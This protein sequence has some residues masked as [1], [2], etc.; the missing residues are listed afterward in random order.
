M[1]IRV[2]AEITHEVNYAECHMGNPIIRSLHIK[3]GNGEN[4]ILRIRSTPE[5][6]FVYKKEIVLQGDQVISD[7]PLQLNNSFYRQ[8]IQETIDATVHVELVDVNYQSK[9][10]A[11]V[12]EPVRV[13]AYLHWN[14]CENPAALA[15]FMQPND[16]FIS[17]VLGRAGEL[18]NKA[19]ESMCGYFAE[20]ARVI[21]QAQWIYTALQEEQVHYYCP[22]AGFEPRG[23]KIRIPRF[24][25]N[26]ETKQGTC[27]DLAILYATCLEGAS[28]HPVI[29]V[30]TGHA[31]VG[32]FTEKEQALPFICK[33][34][35]EVKEKLAFSIKG[36]TP[37][38]LAT[39]GALVPVECTTYADDRNVSFDNSVATA[40]TAL[41]EDD[42]IFA[43]DV[44]QCRLKG[45][46]PVYAYTD[47]PICGGKQ[48]MTPASPGSGKLERLQQQAMDL[49]LRN[50]LAARPENSGDIL[51]AVSAEKLLNG[52]YTDEELFKAFISGA[53]R[54]FDQTRKLSERMLEMMS[55]NRQSKVSQGVGI[56]YLTVNEIFWIPDGKSEPVSAPLYLCAAEIMRNTRGEMIF[57]ADLEHFAVNRVICELLRQEYMLDISALRDKPGK[58]Y[59]AQMQSLRDVLSVRTGWKLVENRASLGLFSMSDEAIYRGLQ[60]KS[61]WEHDIVRG[62]LEGAMTWDN[63]LEPETEFTGEEAYVFPA[64]SSQRKI[65]RAANHYRAQVVFGP[66]GNGKSQTIVNIIAE[67]IAAGKHVLFVAEKPSAQEVVYEKLKEIGLESF[68]LMLP[69]GEKN[70]SAL[71]AKVEKTLRQAGK[72]VQG[73]NTAKALLAEQQ[74]TADMLLKYNTRLRTRKSD[75]RNLLDLL[76]ESEQYRDV[77]QLDWKPEKPDLDDVKCEATVRAF[78]EIQGEKPSYATFLARL[79]GLEEPAE[80]R[81]AI[82]QTV[83]KAKY[84][85]SCYAS[86]RHFVEK[87]TG[88]RLSGADDREKNERMMLYVSQLL[89]C[90][91][92]GYQTSTPDSEQRMQKIQQLSQQVAMAAPNSP[93]Y[94]EAKMELDSLLRQSSTVNA[95]NPRGTSG[96]LSRREIETL[97]EQDRF[98]KYILSLR[99]FAADRP[100]SEADSLVALAY[101][102]SSGEKPELLEELK[103]L[104]FLYDQSQTA[105]AEARKAALCGTGT[106]DVL[107]DIWLQANA[108]AEKVQAYL[109]V[110]RQG[111]DLGLKE[112]FRQME[113]LLES[114]GLTVEQIVPAF[115]KARNS[116]RIR[117]ALAHDGEDEAFGQKNY[118]LGTEHYRQGENKLREARQMDVFNA[119]SGKI[120][121]L[122]AGVYNDRSLGALQKIVRRAN[123]FGI[124]QLFEEAGDAMQRFYP[125]MIMGPSSV[126]EFIPIDAPQFDLVIFDEGSQLPTYKALIPLSKA[127]RCIIVGDEKQLTPT[128]FFRKEQMDENG[129]SVRR[130]AILEDAIITSMPQNMLRFHYRSQ[131]ENLIAFSNSR[132]YGGEIVS[133]PDNSTVPEGV[134]FVYVEQGVYDRGGERI[135][136]CEAER[137]IA[138][139]Q[140]IYEALPEDS[141]ETVGIITFNVEQ[142]RYIQRLLSEAVQKKQ[143]FWDKMEQLVDVVNLESCQG[144]EWDNT[145]LSMT[146]GPDKNGDFSSNLGPMNQREGRNRLNVM[147]TRSRKMLYVVSSMTPEMLRGSSSAGLTD[148]RDFLAFARGD[149][150]LDTRQDV[151]RQNCPN[152]EKDL[153]AIVAQRLTER[154]HIVQTDVGSSDCKVDIGILSQNGK[155]YQIGIMLDDF[156][157]NFSIRDYEI[158][159]PDML[160]SK[161]WTLYRLYTASWYENAEREL[162]CVEELLN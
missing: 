48:I 55:E 98:E 39:G 136:K 43:V 100:E 27:L 49:S 121:N 116:A 6:L 72:P 67:Q 45:I 15:A 46:H 28:I 14:G 56:L 150:K 115:R 134:E 93:S 105:A 60:E 112:L 3:G 22:P 119:V 145:I 120:P 95:P 131:H 25:L 91:V 99:S 135:N 159:I 65:I 123:G 71:A 16:S 92:L 41:N 158:T 89:K 76:L 34:Y 12:Q 47:K 83:H 101:E 64:D 107:L 143:I 94:R 61:L 33:N 1:D 75:G 113:E 97:R 5:F 114:G 62:I 133:F 88:L 69:D 53:E 7:L 57:R 38:L 31:F 162:A 52:E 8:E 148:L 128:S 82:A 2:S 81:E 77:P 153:K 58:D 23:Q 4:A 160:K 132:Y 70:V 138:L 63:N 74:Q 54:P 151:Q 126:A 78:A 147:I 152:D 156:S 96:L 36:K 85:Q 125:C 24:V 108:E 124:R 30:I 59:E 109:E 149:L 140:S 80:K 106:A 20:P 104:Q 155:N 139:V 130:E 117:A 32:F 21:R 90:P 18:A 44:A 26:D 79:R 142:Q 50:K 66:A 122:S 19:G 129:F 146:Y 87:T 73:A 11:F 110:L 84:A 13:Q 42:F 9:I 40:L 37:K 17:R 102:I 118:A 111:Q 141:A 86:K 127:K 10:L 103:A 68:C 29:F 154:G 137:V 35:G 144:K 157:G 161:G 51:F